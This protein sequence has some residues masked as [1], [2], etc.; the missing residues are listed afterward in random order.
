MSAALAWLLHQGYLSPGAVVL[1]CCWL[2]ALVPVTR[3][4]LCLGWL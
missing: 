3:R 2:A 4:R 1:A